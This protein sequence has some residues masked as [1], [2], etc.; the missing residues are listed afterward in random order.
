[1]LG[2]PSPPRPA[3]DP[4]RPGEG[5]TAVK[6]QQRGLARWSPVSRFARR[7]WAG[8]VIAATVVAVSG[9][10]SSAARAATDDK[11]TATAR[12]V[13]ADTITI[14]FAYPDLDAL[15]K[16]SFVRISHGP[17]DPIVRAL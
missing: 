2:Q 4:A 17:Y 16:T 6:T 15:T 13:T 3:T 1:M 5:G 9:I 7:A 12:G 11:S 8:A 10:S 14:G